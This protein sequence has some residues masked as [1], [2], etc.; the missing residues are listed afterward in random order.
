MAR[1][2]I[3]SSE[4]DAHSRV[5][6]WSL[7]AVGHEVFFWDSM[8]ASQFAGYSVLVDNS[9]EVVSVAGTE[10]YDA[11]WLR[12][13]YR[14]D[15][16]PVHTHATDRDF[17]RH[18]HRKF[19]DGVL[20][21]LGSSGM[22]WLN[23]KASSLFAESKIE[24]LHAC[25]VLGIPFPETAITNDPGL[26]RRFVKTNKDYVVKPLDVHTWENADGS[27]LM[28]YTAGL[29]ADLLDTFSDES[30]LLAPAIYQERVHSAH[31]LRV[32][33]INGKTFAVRIENTQGTIDFRQHQTDGT[34]VF[35]PVKVPA[36]IHQSLCR[37]CGHFNL[38][39]ASS[40]FCVT[41]EGEYKFLDLNPGGAFLFV[42][43]WGGGDLIA[44]VAR[45]LSGDKASYF[46]GLEEYNQH[47]NEESRIGAI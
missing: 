25:R 14:P 1:I 5:V 29:N 27:R 10:S 15:S 8:L 26:I 11:A 32:V 34:L 13:V 6:A 42:E 3:V 20:D 43:Y 46:P 39:M 16:F 22:R 17:V 36:E 44:E 38:Q 37:L 30:L 19:L 21:R 4:N 40:D 24:Q 12:R 41:T 7:R 9:G 45:F 35:T 2:L 23:N 28:S 47:S 31:E 18:Q 33:Y